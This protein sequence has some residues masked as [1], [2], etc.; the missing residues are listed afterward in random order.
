MSKKQPKKPENKQMSTSVLITLIVCATV[1]LITIAG[2]IF[3]NMFVNDFGV[4]NSTPD[5]FYMGGN[6][7]KTVRDDKKDAD[8]IG[9]D[10]AREIVLTDADVADADIKY[11]NIYLDSDDGQMKYEIEFATNNFEYDYEIDATTGDIIDS[12]R[13]NI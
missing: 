4:R 2:M 6:S 12:E 1:F 13:E 5:I 10:K 9:K 11:F 3:S 7:D 8:Y